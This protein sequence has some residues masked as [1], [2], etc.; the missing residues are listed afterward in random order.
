MNR[1]DALKT[2]GSGFGMT[3]L[4]GMLG[5]TA[6]H[7]SQAQP[8]GTHFAPKA[9]RVIFLFLNGGPSQ[10]DTFDP[11]PALEKFHGTTEPG[12]ENGIIA[13]GN[14]VQAGTLMKSPF[15]FKKYGQSGIE[16]SSIFPKLGECID[17]VCVVRSM[18]SDIPNHP[19]GLFM[20]NCGTVV[21]GRP[22]LGSWLLYGLGTENQNLPGF[23]VLAPG[24]PIMAPQIWNSAFLPASYQGTWVNTEHADPKKLIPFLQNEQVGLSHQRKQVDLLA[25]LNEMHLKQQGPAPELEATIQ[26]METAF[27]MQT[28]AVEAFDITKESEATRAAYGSGEFARGC[29]MSRRLVERGVRMVQVYFGALQPWDSHSDIM[30]H[31]D[32]AQKSDQPIA[33]LLRD[34]KSRGLLNDTLVI[35]GGEFGRTPAVEAKGG[36]IQNGRDHNTTG[37]TMLLAGGGVKGGTIYGAT[38]ELGR[39]AVEKP[40]HVHDLHATILHLCGFD[41]TKLT[42]RFSGRDF[43]LTDVSGSVIQGL[44]A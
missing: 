24:L 21:A 13:P 5:S 20:M 42:Y 9:K 16:V 30:D 17:D 3:A 40:V 14:I 35:I 12:W 10:V 27:R 7:G 26:G 28:E 22:A 2:M 31:R 6:I 19:Q 43:R 39:R 29:L 34:L 36:A 38:D 4:G 8:V 25:S 33:A 41:H 15:T 32:L 1:R 23:V 18:Y 37:F 11:K 44:I